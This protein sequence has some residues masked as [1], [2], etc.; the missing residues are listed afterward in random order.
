MHSL[1]ITR[2][3]LYPLAEE[4]YSVRMV[5]LVLLLQQGSM[6]FH[7]GLDKYQDVVVIALEGEL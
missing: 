2:V 1:L 5:C 3:S 4:E 7:P 6:Y